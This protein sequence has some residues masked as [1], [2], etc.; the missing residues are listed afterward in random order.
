MLKIAQLN[1]IGLVIR[2]IRVIKVVFIISL[3]AL[4]KHLIL[5]MG[6]SDLI[7]QHL[8]QLQ[9]FILMD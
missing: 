6:T 7:M 3:M 2:E 5:E 1:L 9:Q 8:D 4:A